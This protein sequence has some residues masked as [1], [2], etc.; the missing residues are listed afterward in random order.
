MKPFQFV[1]LISITFL[2]FG[3]FGQYKVSGVIS[4]ENGI[5]IPFAKVYIQNT[6]DSRTIANVDGYYEFRLFEGEY[7]LV[8]ASTGYVTA[9]GYVSISNHEVL[10]Q[11]FFT[12][13]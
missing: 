12:A 3:V 2:S 10:T 11:F 13:G 6:P 9:E 1:L 5:P 7:F 8:V 4:D